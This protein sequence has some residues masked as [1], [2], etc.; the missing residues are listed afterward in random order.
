MTWLIFGGLL[1][2]AG[3]LL[4][5]TFVST[6]PKTLANFIRYL[7]AAVLILLSIP[8]AWRAG[9]AMAAPLVA[10]ALMIL[11][12]RGGAMPLSMGG[13][14]RAFGRARKSP[15]QTSEIHTE[16]L[17]VTLDHDTGQMDGQVVTGQHRGG[18]LSALGI[19]ELLDLL[20]TCRATDP[21]AAALLETYLE[22]HRSDE[23][24]GTAYQ[25]GFGDDRQNS[26]GQTGAQ[27]GAMSS[28]EA[29][30][31]LGLEPGASDQDIVNAYRHLM[32]KLHPDQGGSNY[33]AGKIN[34]AKE[35]LLDK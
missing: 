14:G 26:S 5:Q 15:G 28:Q 33:L 34:R 32:K 10:M 8:V 7:A 31:V 22:R 16:T 35:V 24:D 29:Y 23:L 2:F 30:A 19:D 11:G 25:N 27:T 12:W 13:L 9:V 20:T 21:D 18:K 6:N 17:H 4:L 3:F 1:F